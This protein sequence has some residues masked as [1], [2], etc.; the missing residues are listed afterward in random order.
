M[1]DL[2]S[3]RDERTGALELGVAKFLRAGVIL[4][5]ALLAMG[6]ALSLRAGNPLAA[7]KEYAPVPFGT[8]VREAW[9]QRD[10]ALLLSFAGL[11]V[12]VSLPPLRVI[13]TAVLLARAREHVLA[14][15]AVFVL[16]VLAGSFLLG[17]DVG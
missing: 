9:R 8:A 12:L 5:G 17:W 11:S 13:F 15:I 14:L 2:E 1:N 6:W 7:F 16:L 4:S 3:A 10:T